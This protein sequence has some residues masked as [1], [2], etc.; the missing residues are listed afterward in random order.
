V[1]K[2]TLLAEILRLP[3]DERREL[4]E[5]VFESLPQD[6]A[7][8]VLTEEQKAELDRRLEEHRRDPSSA[9]PADEVIASLRSRFG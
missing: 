3:K 1:N 4:V 7:D 5:E 2:A 6:S 8:F 9:V